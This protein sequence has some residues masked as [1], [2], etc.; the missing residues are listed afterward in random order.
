MQRVKE[1]A[2][3]AKRTLTHANSAQINLPFLAVKDNEPKHLNLTLSKNKFNELTKN[4]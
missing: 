3:D 4:L 2:E 1:A